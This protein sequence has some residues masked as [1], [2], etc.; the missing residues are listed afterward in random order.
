[1]DPDV[2]YTAS[3]V[4]FAFEDIA[5]TGTTLSFG[6]P[7][8]DWQYVPIGFNFQLFQNYFSDFYVNTNGLIGFGDGGND[9]TDLTSSPYYPT[10]APFWDDLVVG[11]GANSKV[12]Y[13]VLG[14][15]ASTHLV[16]Q[17]NDVSFAGDA[18]QAGGLTFQAVL[19]I[20]GSIRFNYQS[21]STGNNGGAHDLGISAT[22]GFK[23]Y[24]YQGPNRLLL[25]YNDGPTSLVNSGTSV[26]MTP[27]PPADYYSFTVSAGETD[28]LAVTGIYGSDL[29]VELLDGSGSLIAIGHQRPDEFDEGHQRHQPGYWRHLLCAN[30]WSRELGL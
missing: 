19:G 27:A 26:V 17:W 22:A 5:A 14:S 11:G 16:I 29:N 1:M 30:H 21:L 23:D 9:N 12:V 3:S 13:Q 18:P 6:N 8:D 10:I 24:Y 28:T 7:D 25:M 15:G 20:D 2:H 4:P